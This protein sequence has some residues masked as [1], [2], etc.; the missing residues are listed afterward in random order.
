M[1]DWAKDS[2]HILIPVESAEEFKELLEE[3]PFTLDFLD[4]VSFFVDLT[5]VIENIDD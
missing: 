1:L 5:I 4:L 2:N 3:L